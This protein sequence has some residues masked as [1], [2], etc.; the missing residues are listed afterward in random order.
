MST[1]AQHMPILKIFDF[2]QVTLVGTTSLQKIWQC[3]ICALQHKMF[4]SSNSGR[5]MAK[6]GSFGKPAEKL[7]YMADLLLVFIEV[8]RY[9]V[10]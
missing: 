1:K 9:R 3:L 6:V 5:R 10:E 4:N 8:S 7:L 2:K